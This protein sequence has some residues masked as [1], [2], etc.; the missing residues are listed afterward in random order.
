MSKTLHIKTF[1]CQMNVY[2]SKK[3]ED[4]LGALGYTSTPELTADVVLLNTCHIRE[5]AEDK[6]FS[7]LGRFHV[8]KKERQNNGQDMVIVVAGCSAQALGAHILK[9]APYVD[10]VVGPQTYYHLPQMLA[11]LQRRKD[12]QVEGENKPFKGVL[13]TGFP[14]ISKF[15]QLPQTSLT[16]P[17]SAF[18]SIQEGC[19][20]FCTYCVVPY[21]RG[22]EYSRDV[23]SI[24]QE[25]RILLEK[26]VKE[27]TLLGQNVNAY[28]GKNA[29]GHVV[30]LSFLLQRLAELP[31]LKRLRYTTSHPRDMTDDLIQ[32]HGQIDIL[33][34]FLHL[35]V[36]SGSDKILAHMNRQH[37]TEFYLE[38]INALK[39]ARPEIAFSSDFIVGYPGETQEDFQKTCDLVEKVQFAQAYSFMYSPRPGTPAAIQDQIPGEVK[40][41]RLQI[42]Q[43]LLRQHQLAFNRSMEGKVLP[44]LLE[45]KGQRP[46]QILGRSPFM[47][48]VYLSQ[49]ALGQ[50][51]NVQITS[52]FLNSLKG[53][54]VDHV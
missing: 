42:L 18:L 32:A 24:I 52:G 28:H 20:K 16:G 35:P 6:L 21:T 29:N 45:K 12:E 11:M 48:S 8:L 5:K 3:I 54:V 15:D 46:G 47:Q 23:E 43:A 19:D 14:K 31:D 25:A 44:I 36:Q 51:I 1:G 17:V 41:E 10:M 34:P 22:A 9:R 38:K 4:M 40:A 26:G 33:M 39:N 2:D 50:E 37:T 53:E 49:G 7:D 13:E 30:G 27:I